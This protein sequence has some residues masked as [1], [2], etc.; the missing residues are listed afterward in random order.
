MSSFLQEVA[1]QVH[2]E[3]GSQLSG[4][5]LICANRR[6]GLFLRQELARFCSGPVFLPE[7]L[8]FK[9]FILQHSPLQEADQLLLI[10]RLYAVFKELGLANEA[11][12]RFYFWGDMLLRDFDEI[13]KFLV[14]TRL[15]FVNLRRL[16]ELDLGLDY[17][18]ERQLTLIRHFWSSFGEKDA[19][20]QEQFLRIWGLLNEAH[21][22]LETSLVADG[23]AYEGLIYRHFLK[24]LEQGKVAIDELDCLFVGFNALNRSEE[25]IIRWFITHRKSRMA[26]DMDAYY[27]QKPQHEA[28]VFFRQYQ[29]D[30]VLGPTL[31][32]ELPLRLDETKEM[33]L[34]A[35]PTAV[36]QV[37][38]LGRQLEKLFA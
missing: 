38:D 34:V 18:D 16:K 2:G 8:S 20:F 17:L 30:A 24:D 15:L 36:A 14:D 13:D 6:A 5:R 23:W 21:T 33:E 28:G 1:L 11:F 31:P 35:A 27:V 25:G 29:Q 10:H 26:W 4:L 9:D 3:Y 22:R 12:D 7:I 37:K 32:K 19:R